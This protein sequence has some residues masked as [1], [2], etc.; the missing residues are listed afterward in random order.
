MNKQR[1]KEEIDIIVKDLNKDLERFIGMPN[2]DSTKHSI[3]SISLMHFRKLADFIND[4]SNIDIDI[5]SL[6]DKC[7]LSI[8]PKNIYTGLLLSGNYRPHFMCRDKDVFDDGT[9]RAWFINDVFCIKY[10]GHEE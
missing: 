3:K 1:I 10:Y 2:T 8:S 7:S 9:I 4:D 5:K 6:E